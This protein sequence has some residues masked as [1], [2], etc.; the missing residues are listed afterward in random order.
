MTDI[1]PIYE[2]VSAGQLR[3]L[4]EFLKVRHDWHEPDEQEVTVK[5]QGSKFDN[6]GVEGEREVI[7]YQAKYPIAKINL[8]TLFAFAT[9]TDDGYSDGDKEFRAY[10]RK[11]TQELRH[12]G[13]VI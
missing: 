11:K 4:A 1:H 13:L 6:A 7:I 12:E 9:R 2:V 10:L 8:A 3:D 5:V